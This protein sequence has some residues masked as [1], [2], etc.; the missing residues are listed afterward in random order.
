MAISIF[1]PPIGATLAARGAQVPPSSRGPP[2]RR[3][4]ARPAGLD[5]D[6]LRVDATD[7]RSE[8]YFAAHSFDRLPHAVALEGDPDHLRQVLGGRWW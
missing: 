4:R 6:Y 2:P 5:G 7:I 1:R 3:G 8:G